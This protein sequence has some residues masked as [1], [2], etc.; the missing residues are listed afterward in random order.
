MVRVGWSNMLNR[1]G[2][3]YFRKAVPLPLRSII[4]KREILVSL[5]DQ[6]PRGCEVTPPPRRARSGCPSGCLE[7]E[8]RRADSS[9]P[10]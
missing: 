5:K 4:G 8:A 9:S 10:R 1:H 2:V 6:G 3:Y 7:E